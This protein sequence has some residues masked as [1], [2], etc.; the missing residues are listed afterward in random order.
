[1]LSFAVLCRAVL[2]CVPALCKY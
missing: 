2:A 1:V